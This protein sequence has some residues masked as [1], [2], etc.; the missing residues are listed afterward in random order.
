MRIELI[1]AQSAQKVKR[2]PHF[3]REDV[4]QGRVA[5]ALGVM[6]DTVL[7]A[8]VFYADDGVGYEERTT[9]LQGYGTT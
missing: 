8:P 2:S 4:A 7:L 9:G 3:L 6:G 1:L 5:L